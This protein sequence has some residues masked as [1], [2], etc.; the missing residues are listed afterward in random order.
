V[1]EQIMGRKLPQ[2]RDGFLR[3]MEEERR[4]AESALPWVAM[5]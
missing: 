1:A 5:G 2:T 3:I 4:A